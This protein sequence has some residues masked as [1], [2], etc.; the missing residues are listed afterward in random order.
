[1]IFAIPLLVS[2]AVAVWFCYWSTSVFVG[3]RTRPCR[4]VCFATPVLLAVPALTFSDA[5]L[6]PLYES[7][8]SFL[9]FSWL[10]EAT[11]EFVVTLAMIETIFT[12][13]I[14]SLV[15]E[16]SKLGGRRAA[17]QN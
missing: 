12:L 13:L 3:L 4:V 14:M 11:G 6:V 16:L 7:M 1:M 8:P 10:G 17:S 9:F 15:N 5:I 2:C